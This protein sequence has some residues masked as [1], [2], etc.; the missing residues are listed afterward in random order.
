MLASVLSRSARFFLVA[1]IIYFFG[2]QVGGFIEEYF[3]LVTILFVVLLIG[4]FLA[5]R[6]GWKRKAAHE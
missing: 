3:N 5:M 6:L 4:G 2:S 1:T